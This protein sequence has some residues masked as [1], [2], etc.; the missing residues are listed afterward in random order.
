MNQCKADTTNIENL[1]DILKITTDLNYA[2]LVSE[3]PKEAIEFV[4]HT[5]E[6]IESNKAHLQA[7]IFT[8]GRE[9]LIPGMFMSIVEKIYQ[10]FPE[11]ISIFKYY[12]ERH[13]EVDGDKH[14]HLALQMTSNL[15][16]TDEKFWQEAEVAIVDTLQ[17]RIDLWDGVYR[18]IQSKKVVF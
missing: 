5:F 7:A 18:V 4:K 1:I 15:C 13:I 12:L 17:K 6:I 8:F 14:G 9:D 3:T 16:G 2:F 10:N 11:S